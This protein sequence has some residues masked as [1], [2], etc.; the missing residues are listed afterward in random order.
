MIRRARLTM[1]VQVVENGKLAD[2]VVPTHHVA[3]GRYGPHFRVIAEKALAD[4]REERRK[5]NPEIDAGRVAN[6]AIKQCRRRE[7]NLRNFDHQMCAD[8]VPP[9]DE[10]WQDA[11]EAGRPAR[12]R[13]SRGRFAK[14]RDA[15]RR[16]FEKRTRKAQRSRRSSERG[17]E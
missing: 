1:V 16:A 3:R 15:V 5:H 2:R 12:A 9:R 10:P 6:A 8:E 14:A 11:I 7:R 13:T 4:R 17:V